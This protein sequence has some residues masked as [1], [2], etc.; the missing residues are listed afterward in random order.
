MRTIGLIGGMSW[1]STAITYQLLNQ[2]ARDRLGSLHSAQLLLWSFDF[3]EIEAH[4]ASGDWDA[5]TRAMVDAAQ[6]L[7]AGGAACLMICSNTMHRMAD[8]VQAATRIPL[9]HI[10]DVTAA[11]IKNAGLKKPLLLATRYTMEQD[12]YVGRLRDRHGLDV[13]VP[14]A[15]GR[16]VVHD[17]I[18]DELCQGVVRQESKQA[19]LGVIG[20]TRTADPDVDSVILGCTEVGM[21]IGQDDLDISVFDTTGLHAQA[22]L[23]FALDS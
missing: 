15:A 11:A 14:D 21:L 23:E 22:A 10:A 19:Y 4:Q 5:A 9:I 17:I 1:E 13:I 3:A 18:Y 16:T 8:E 20:H 6:R 12:F 2:M 7:E